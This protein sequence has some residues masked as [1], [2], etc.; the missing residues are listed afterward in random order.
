M[1]RYQTVGVEK[2]VAEMRALADQYGSLHFNFSNDV[3]DPVYLK[4]LSQ[5]MLDS[6]REFIWNTDLR[7]EKTYD[8]QTCQLMAKAGL[9][10]VAI[11]FESGCQKTLDAMDKGKRVETVARV[12][13]NLYTAGV[14]T[15]AMG[16]F[17]MP[18]ETEADG[19]QTVRFLEANADYIS[20]Y[21]M[22]LLM[23]LPGS[24]MHRDPEAHGVTA[25]S[26]DRNPLKTPEPVWWSDTRMS[27]ASV[28]MLY[29][30]LSRLEEIYAIDEYP[31]VG[32]LSTNHGFL[33][34]TLGPDILKRLRQ[35]ENTEQN[36]IRRLLGLDGPVPAAKTLKTMV[37]RQV[38]P[39]NLHRSRFALH[40]LAPESGEAQHAPELKPASETDFFLF[41]GDGPQLPVMVGRQEIR[42]LNRIDGRRS[43]WDVLKKVEKPAMKRGLAFI[44]F[45]V[46]NQMI[47]FS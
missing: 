6:G 36:T 8:A 27:L 5:G 29:A 30:R 11:G 45:L 40:R 7:A 13:Q 34:Y 19:E 16:I 21:V 15:Q 37:P 43:L 18:G 26:Y 22:G 42:L 24:R 9:K 35:A 39:F 28:N 47:D 20:Y 25:I 31:Y 1:R 38:F 33:Y 14:A 10:S 46:Q 4:K 2:A 3:V 41:A 32:G 23:V 12:L 17:G 44:G